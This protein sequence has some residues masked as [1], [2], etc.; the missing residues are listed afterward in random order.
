MKLTG[1]C[2]PLQSG[3][4]NV[5]ALS[6]LIAVAFLGLAFLT[7]CSPAATAPSTPAVAKKVAPP[8]PLVPVDELASKPE[9]FQGQFNVS[10][11]VIE[12][13]PGGDGF[14]LGCEDACVR[15][16]VRFKGKAPKAQADVIVRGRVAKNTDGLYLVE[17][18]SVDRP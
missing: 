15:I 17:A 6:L 12:V 14:T 11:R 8:P 5:A 4:R 13:S 1:R 9:A 10:G 16:P 2:F 3:N 7:S 18:D